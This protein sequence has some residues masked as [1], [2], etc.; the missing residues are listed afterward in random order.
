M[1]DKVYLKT[2][3]K[4]DFYELWE[5]R[6]SLHLPDAA[7]VQQFFA[8]YIET[9]PRLAHGPFYWH[10]FEN[11]GAGSRILLAGGAVESLTPFTGNDLLNMPP[12]RFFALFHPD[13]LQ[14][15]FAF[16]AQ[17]L[18]LLA[19]GGQAQRHHF[20]IYMRMARRP[21]FY[22]WFSM[23]YPAL[24]YDGTDVFKTG[25]VVYTHVQH[26]AAGLSRPMLTQI[27]TQNPGNPMLTT[28]YAGGESTVPE[29]FPSMSV[30]EREVVALLSQGKSS[31]QIAARLGIAK[32]TVDNHRQ[33]LLK[34]FNVHSSSE[35]VIKAALGIAGMPPRFSD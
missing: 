34:K 6:K 4:E 16:M 29:V 8:P 18:N 14:P 15:T 17:M 35:L 31:K 28:Y 3:S 1:Q 27:D 32:N 33:R 2:F 13:D 9:L 23:Q 7:T 5:D 12:E 24:Y 25:M 20:T 26:L 10:I 22:E 19:P 21:G 30:R 11:A